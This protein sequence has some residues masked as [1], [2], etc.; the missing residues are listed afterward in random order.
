MM[1]ALTG[2]PLDDDLIDR[3]LIFCPTFETLQSAILVSKHFYRVFET[4]PKSITRAVAYNV[5]GAALPAALRVIRYPYPIINPEEEDEEEEEDG[6]ADS[7]GAAFRTMVKRSKLDPHTLGEAC[8]EVHGPSIMTA[9]EKNRL[10]E[11]AETM[12]QFEDIYSLRNKDRT[13]RTSKLT[14]DESF[15]FR[16]AAFR[17]MLYC[18]IFTSEL[19][20]DEDE[21]DLLVETFDPE[22]LLRVQKQR[23]AVLSAY[24]SE[25]LR[26]MHSVLTFMKDVYSSM[27]SYYGDFDEHMGALLSLGPEGVVRTWRDHSLDYAH[28]HTSHLLDLEQA[29]PLFDADYFAKPMQSVWTRRNA[30][31]PKA[32]EPASTY[33]LDEVFGA[34]DTCSQCPTPDGIKLLCRANWD[35]FEAYPLSLLRGKLPNNLTLRMAFDQRT[36]RLAASDELGPW[37]EEVWAC[38]TAPPRA[39]G[40]ASTSASASTS[41]APVP[42]P[43]STNVDV[44]AGDDDDDDDDDK[45]E[46]DSDSENNTNTMLNKYT[47]DWSGW[48]PDLSYC[49][50][51]FME[52]LLD[53]VWRWWA[54]EWPKTG[55]IVPTDDCWYGYNCN[56]QTHRPAHAQKLNHLCVPTRGDP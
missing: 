41:S 30:K 16:Q 55:F 12:Q 7:E 1:R 42:I 27:A 34:N 50:S 53:H 10:N 2:L 52:F 35:R 51:C 17:I 8:P 5:V 47:R 38:N 19:D 40:S 31:A 46:S 36:G 25:E 23:A 56:T 22:I 37:I 21:G 54:T 29:H 44:A 28:E 43:T 4:H 14:P 48:D 45:T 18:N 13:S 3:I 9:E 24:D 20:G 6:A 33:I 32:N 11:L 39:S 49:K 15:V 26:E